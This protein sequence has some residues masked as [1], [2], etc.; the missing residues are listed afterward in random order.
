MLRSARSTLTLP[1]HL[2]SKIEE[3]CCTS[4]N[5]LDFGRRTAIMDLLFSTENVTP[6]KR[7]QLWQEVVAARIS[8]ANH[9][10]EPDRVFNAKIETAKVDN[11]DFLKLTNSAGRSECSSS[12]IKHSIYTGKVFVS[13]QLS[14]ESYCSQDDRSSVRCPGEFV[15][16]D[17]RP[18]KILTK[19][20]NQALV[21]AIPRDRIE[22]VLGST[23]RYTALTIGRD[24][25]GTSLAIN[26]LT[27]LIDVS[28]RLSADASVRMATI[29]IDLIVA[30]VAERL[31]LHVPQSLQGTIVVQRAKAYVEASFHDPS[32]DPPQ[33]AA[34][35]GISLRRL[36]QLFQEQ[37]VSISNWIWRYRLEAAARRLADPGHMH[38]SISE[39]AYSCGFNS[40]SHFTR[41]FKEH[42]GLTPRDYRWHSVIS[43][44][45]ISVKA[46]RSY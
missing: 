27:K 38:L 46:S 18:S 15:V 33:L 4:F 1:S 30:S 21:V 16:I 9:F 23:R 41:R 22:K 42:Y 25:A 24:L 10:I 11:I 6:R 20:D 45:E 34:A 13:I 35:L 26:F 40:Q 32:L 43:L 37:N 28:N 14:G 19:F 3:I 2:R 8:A 36:Q 17:N 39:I 12:Q 5:N 44:E 7:F 31:A 29:G